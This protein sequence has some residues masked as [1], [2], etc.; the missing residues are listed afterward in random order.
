MVEQARLPLSTAECKKPLRGAN[1]F[2]SIFAQLCVFLLSLNKYAS[3][4]PRRIDTYTCPKLFWKCYLFDFFFSPADRECRRRHRF[5]KPPRPTRTALCPRWKKRNRLF[6]YAPILLLSITRR[7]FTVSHFSNRR[8]F[9]FR[10]SR[11]D[12]ATVIGG[13]RY[14]GSFMKIDVNCC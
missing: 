11:N 10:G 9:H 7:A 5:F 14:R 12:V 2:H 1:T 6:Y 13:E 8:D 4:P 3:P